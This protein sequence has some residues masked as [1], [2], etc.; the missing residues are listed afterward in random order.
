MKKGILLW[1]SMLLTWHQ[2]VADPSHIKDNNT[3]KEIF[4]NF[5]EN[6]KSNKENTVSSEEFLEI[7]QWDIKQKIINWTLVYF[8]KHVTFKLTPDEKTQLKHDLEKFLSKYPNIISISGDN[9]ILNITESQFQ[10]FFKVL[11]PYF[12]KWEALRD[13]PKIVRENDYAILRH[14]RKSKWEKAEFY[15][16]HYFGYLI[17]DIVESLWNYGMTID[18]YTA[19]M[20]SVMPNAYIQ[21]K[22]YDKDMLNSDIRNLPKYF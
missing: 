13:Y 8:D 1:L 11:L 20:L 2:T 10:E 18:Y 16:F 4:F 3:E 22:N 12:G 9:V 17:M 14:I 21:E 6:Q 5:S 7:L 19:K 15:F